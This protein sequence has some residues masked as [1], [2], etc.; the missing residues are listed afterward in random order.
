MPARLLFTGRASAER[1]SREPISFEKC[2]L[3]A[4]TRL[5]HMHSAIP[6]MLRAV[7]LLCL[8]APKPFTNISTTAKI[9]SAGVGRACIEGVQRYPFV[10]VAI[11]LCY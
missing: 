11:C 9:R 8:S 2:E 1:F 10:S 6:L 3:F 7:H 4:R 5:L